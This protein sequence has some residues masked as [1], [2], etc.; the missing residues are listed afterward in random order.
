MT[1][2]KSR[3]K[4]ADDHPMYGIRF[5]ANKGREPGYLVKIGRRNV[6]HTK[7]FGIGQFGGDA[8]ALSAAQAWRDAQIRALPVVSKLEYVSKI[9]PNNTSGAAG[10]VRVTKRNRKRSGA[11]VC[12]DYWVAR[13]PR[14]V[15]A[16]QCYFSIPKY[17]EERAWELAVKA[18]REME[19]LA[20]GQYVPNAPECFVE[21]ATGGDSTSRNQNRR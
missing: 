21:L 5:M 16:S 3:P 14:S 11:V 4:T 10:V 2:Q 20:V 13:P 9:R 15:K 7:W 1:Q 17:G 12:T 6:D 8:Q 18:R 19:Q